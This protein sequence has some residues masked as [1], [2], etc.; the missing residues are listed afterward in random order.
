LK[1]WS[2]TSKIRAL[3]GSLSL[4][5]TGAV[6]T[7]CAGPSTPLG[8]VW[9][10]HPSQVNRSLASVPDAPTQTEG[11][12]GVHIDFNPTRQ[13]LHGPKPLVVRI[14]DLNGIPEDPKLQVRYDGLDVTTTFLSQAK[15]LSKSGERELFIRIPVVRL[16]PHT[17]HKI[18][19][20]YY[21]ASG[22]PS[23]AFYKAPV[24]RAFDYKQVK[25]TD[26]F[27]P[28]DSLL[29][30]IDRLSQEAE[31]NPALTTA[32]IAQE[33]SFNPRTVSWAKAMGLTQMTPIAEDEISDQ[34]DDYQKWPHYK[35]VE[36]IPASVLKMMVM[37]GRINARNDWRLDQEL[38]VKGGL[39]YLKMLQDRWSSPAMKA[40]F[41]EEE[42]TRLIL[43]SYN[44]GSAR[45]MSALGR[46]GKNWIKAPE[47]HEARLY[48][49]R[50]F[51]FCDFFSQDQE[52]DQDPSEVSEV[53]NDDQQT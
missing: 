53:I 37:S 20:R 29:S 19:V 38:S 12:A 50:I 26:S 24:C 49:N 10:F 31:M 7:G 15:K 32:L 9:A 4:A 40:R 43:A 22:R 11:V 23:W 35:G 1:H 33:S 42:R 25:H 18:E 30:I 47:L 39:A 2:Q 8:A 34:F 3:T 45:V 27:T 44:S 6:F 41:D 14:E 13:V 46:Y 21:N 5:V 48:V 16:S 52:K 28:T 36:T 51:S 17:D